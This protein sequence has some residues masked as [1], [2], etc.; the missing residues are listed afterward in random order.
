MKREALMSRVRGR[1]RELHLAWNLERRGSRHDLWKCGETVVTIPR[2]R[3][4][5]ELTATGIMKTLERELGEDWW[6]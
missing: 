4:I 1:A 5:N 3:E 6:R 2:H